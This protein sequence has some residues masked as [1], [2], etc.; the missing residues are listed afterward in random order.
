MKF[1]I[2]ERSTERG[3]ISVVQAFDGDGFYDVA[4]IGA[5]SDGG[6]EVEIYC[7]EVQT[8]EDALNAVENCFGMEIER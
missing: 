6:F 1:R 4:E 3:D 5:L 7:L 2:E 8:F